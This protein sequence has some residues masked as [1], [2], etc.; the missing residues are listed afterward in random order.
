MEISG[1]Y[2]LACSPETAWAALN[3]TDILK[4]SLKG[5]EALE[6]TSAA[7]FTGTVA[8]RIGPVSARFTGKMSQSDIDPPRGCAMTFDG[9]G[10]AAGFAKGKARVTLTPEE[11][12]TRLTYVA[13]AQTGGKLAQ[14][15]ARLIEGVAKAMADDFF[16]KF[17]ASLAPEPAADPAP[18][19]AKA[20]KSAPNGLRWAMITGGVILAAVLLYRLFG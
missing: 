13:D 11:G 10:G 14:M 15:G 5:C 3:D 9:Q 20:A 17:S 7:E 19:E 18:I 4:S 1:S 8:A 16:G 12:G 6:R 2:L